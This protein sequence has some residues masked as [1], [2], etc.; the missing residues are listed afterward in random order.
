MGPVNIAAKA[1][2]PDHSPKNKL[3]T[4]TARSGSSG[5]FIMKIVVTTVCGTMH[6]V[7]IFAAVK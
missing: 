1:T 2:V 3:I 4:K 7:M 5:S 6:P